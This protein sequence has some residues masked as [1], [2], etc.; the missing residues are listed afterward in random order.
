MYFSYLRPDAHQ[1]MPFKLCLSQKM[2]ED[3]ISLT[4]LSNFCFDKTVCKKFLFSS[5]NVLS[6]ILNIIKNIKMYNAT[7][8]ISNDKINNLILIVVKIA[9]KLSI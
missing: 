7:N 2:T 6:N 5:L 8:L 9:Q 3:F 1:N 4:I